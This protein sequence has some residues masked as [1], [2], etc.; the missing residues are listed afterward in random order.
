MKT[1]KKRTA[2]HLL[3]DWLN[4]CLPGAKL[5]GFSRW[6]PPMH[7]PPCQTPEKHGGIRDAG[8]CGEVWKLVDALRPRREHISLDETCKLLRALNDQS[9]ICETFRCWRNHLIGEV[10]VLLRQS[11]GSLPFVKRPADAILS[12]HLS[13]GAKGKLK[14][15]DEDF[16]DQ[17]DGTSEP[18]CLR[19]NKQKEDVTLKH[20]M[21]IYE[22]IHISSKLVSNSKGNGNSPSRSTS[23]T[24]GEK[25]L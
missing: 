21:S 22:P 25:K 17:L 11:L 10:A 5:N 1:N 8:Y 12:W 7:P 3:E 2:V 23:Q 19:E 15:V 6:H 24:S 4:K 13:R 14:Y 18:L 20:S 9:D 16:D